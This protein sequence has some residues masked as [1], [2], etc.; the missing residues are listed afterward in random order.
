MP[1]RQARSICGKSE[2]TLRAYSGSNQIQSKRGN[3]ISQNRERS[4]HEQF[5]ATEE[6]TAVKVDPALHGWHRRVM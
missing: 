5:K 4:Q 2:K 3:K 1:K 6:S